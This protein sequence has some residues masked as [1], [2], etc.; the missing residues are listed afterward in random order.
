M[1]DADILRLAARFDAAS[2]E[3]QRAFLHIVERLADAAGDG[4]EAESARVL[5]EAARETGREHLIRNAEAQ[6]ARFKH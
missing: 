2:A 3:D 6:F 4:T 1:L 5:V